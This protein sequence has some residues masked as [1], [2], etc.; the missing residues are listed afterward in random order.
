M[1]RQISLTEAE[2]GRLESRLKQD[3]PL[4]LE[5]EII[6]EITTLNTKLHLLEQTK[7]IDI[8]EKERKEKSVRPEEEVKEKEKE[9]DRR[10]ADQLQ[11]IREE[12]VTRELVQ[13]MAEDSSLGGVKDV[14]HNFEGIHCIHLHLKIFLSFFL[15]S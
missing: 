14:L 11:T 6:D 1:D 3:L 10:I 4:D 2:I 15:I 9:E 12:R 7:D 5:Q 8:K 13:N